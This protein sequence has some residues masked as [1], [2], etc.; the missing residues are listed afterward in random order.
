MTQ[1]TILIID[2]DEDD[3]EILADAFMQCGVEGVHYVY[4][5]MQA[6]MY[7]QDLATDSLPKL[8]VTDHFLPGITGVE[9]LKDL[10]AMDKYKHLP[11]IVL[12]SLKSDKEIK[13]YQEMGAIDY[14]L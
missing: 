5:A 8:I 10:K 4:T 3:V 1:C 12:A 11:V 6:F 14:L 13:R 7:L 9:F 2:D